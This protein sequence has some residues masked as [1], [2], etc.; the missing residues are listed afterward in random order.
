MINA[1]EPSDLPEHL[2]VGTRTSHESIAGLEAMLAPGLELPQIDSDALDV[3]L[4]TGML[5][6]LMQKLKCFFIA[7]QCFMLNYIDCYFVT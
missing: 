3:I 4:R 2:E 1:G 7:A 5:M 6:N